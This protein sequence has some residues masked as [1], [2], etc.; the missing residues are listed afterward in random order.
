VKPGT[1]KITVNER[2]M[3]DYF[4]RFLYQVMLHQPLSQVSREGT[5]DISI[6]VNGGGLTGQAGACRMGIARALVA[7]DETLRAPLR[8]AG[9]LTRDSRTV[10]RKKYGQKKARK[11]F[12]YS[13]R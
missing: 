3:N 6:N 1:G 8:Q 10:E 12:Q 11:R 2:E 9:F 5:L 4:S 13:K 7:M